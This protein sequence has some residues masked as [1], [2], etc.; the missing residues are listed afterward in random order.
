MS[1]GIFGFGDGNL[2][3][4]RFGVGAEESQLVEEGRVEHDVGVLLIGED[5]LHLAGA[6]TAP[7]FERVE[8]AV[9]A[10]VVVAD[11]A[12]DEAVVAAVE[13]VLAVDGNLGE[14]G[15]VDLELKFVGDGSGELGVEGV[16]A[17]DDED[18]VGVELEG[19]T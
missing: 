8:G 7:T 6:D 18:A 17:F 19:L 14:S 13:D 12:S 2:L 10:E 16:D 5:V 11:D 4:K 15:D 9:A 3:E 1:L